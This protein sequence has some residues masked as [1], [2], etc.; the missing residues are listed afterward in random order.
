MSNKKFLKGLFIRGV[1]PVFSVYVLNYITDK[2][3]IKLFPKL[4]SKDFYAIIVLVVLFYSVKGIIQMVK[5]EIE[6]KKAD[7]Q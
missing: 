4:E 2:Y 7:N 5:A 6:R 1:L 3:N